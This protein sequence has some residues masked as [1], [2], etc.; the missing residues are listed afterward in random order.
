MHTRF[1]A[2]ALA[3]FMLAGPAMAQVVVDYRD[4]AVLDMAD[5]AQWSGIAAEIG[6]DIEVLGEVAGAFTAAGSADVAYLVSSSASV[7]A[8]PF[9]EVAQRIVVYSGGAQVADWAL[10]ADA[11]FSRPVTAVDMDGDGVDE[12]ILEGSFYNMGTMAIGLSAIRLGETAE[13]VQVLT[14]V[15]V[16]SC[17]AGVGEQTVTAS[18]VTVGGGELVAE[19]EGVEC[20]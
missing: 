7:A 19:A 13:V 17:E 18:V 8:D 16:D 6:G 12:V 20:P 3:P 11:A 9:P 10:P 1:Y 5:P 14:D 4:N 2:F 15:Y